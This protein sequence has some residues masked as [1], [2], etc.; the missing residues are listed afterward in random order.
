MT[1]PNRQ[2]VPT[3]LSVADAEAALSNLQGKRDALIERGKQL[4]TVRASYAYAAHA[5]DDKVAREKL[6]QVNR[7]TAEH[8]SELASI[9]A[10]LKRATDRLEAAKRHEA[11]QADREQAKALREALK[12]FVQHGAGVDAALEVLI[13]SCNGLQTALIE[14]HRSG[15]S[16][17]SDAQL[18]SLGGRVLLGAL[19][20]TPFRRN[21]ETLPPDQRSRTM[22]M[23]VQQWSDTVE[24]S[25]RERLGDQTTSTTEAA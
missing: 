3:I 7:E 12:R 10:A 4:D 16:F 17:P 5:N 20:R 6:D 1:R 9:D 13:E 11:K 22:S 25:I 8:G 19:S 2:T 23:V 21:F 18:M 24:R 14:M 15:S